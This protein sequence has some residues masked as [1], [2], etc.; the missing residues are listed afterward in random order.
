MHLVHSFLVREGSGFVV[1]SKSWIIDFLLGN[2]KPV[3]RSKGGRP[4]TT[5][6]IEHILLP[7]AQSKQWKVKGK[8]KKKEAQAPAGML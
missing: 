2:T 5:E 4:S 6:F 8:V 7:M 3:Y 1:Q